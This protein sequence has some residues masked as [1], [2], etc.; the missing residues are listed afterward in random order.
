MAPISWLSREPDPLHGSQ[1]DRSNRVPIQLCV[2][3]TTIV[4]YAIVSGDFRTVYTGGG[5]AGSSSTGASVS[6]AWSAGHAVI[7]DQG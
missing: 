3:D 6:T 5:I 2:T 1:S 7:S 4:I